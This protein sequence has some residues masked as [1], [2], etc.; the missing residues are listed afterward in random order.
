MMECLIAKA[1]SLGVR[2]VCDAHVHDLVRDGDRIVGVSYRSFGEE[3]GSVR[4][5]KGVILA[6]GQFT[7]NEQ[8]LE[9]FVP[10]LLNEGYTLQFAPYD[11]GAGHQL[12]ELAGGT[13]KHMDGRLVTSAFYPPESHLKGVLV[14]KQGKRYVAED[15]YHSRSSIFTTQQPDRA[16][17]LILD[18][19][20]YAP[21]PPTW[22]AA[23]LVDAWETVEEMEKGLG[24][25]E[26][27]LQETLRAYNENAARG[28]DPEFHKGAKWLQPLTNPPYAA[29]D[30][31]MGHATYMAFTLGGLDVSIDGEVL[32]G[33]QKP[34]P[35]LY[36]I[37]G[38]AS[39]IAQDGTGY[40]SGTCIGESTFFGRRA[41]RRVAAL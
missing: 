41:G 6:A 36:A 21:E 7:E 26:G 17:Y 16:G 39:N 33:E 19:A 15:S 23:P 30:V 20:T 37:G 25:P 31:S 32:D 29:L 13:L 11:D 9:R 35:G 14:N 8:L 27:S 2:I 34:I 1:E 40:S 28:T 10:E 24:L 12:G 5:R 4:G 3:K 38:C 18:E 22:G